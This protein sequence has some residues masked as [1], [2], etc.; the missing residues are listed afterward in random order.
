MPCNKILIWFRLHHICPELQFYNYLNEYFIDS[1]NLSTG[2][3]GATPG[4]KLKSVLAG[5][6]DQGSLPKWKT[7]D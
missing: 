7:F 2:L 1:L 3:T 5:S 4:K 6:T